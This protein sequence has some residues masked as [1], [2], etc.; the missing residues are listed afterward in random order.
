MRKVNRQTTAC[1][2]IFFERIKK[3]DAFDKLGVICLVLAALIV[4]PLSLRLFLGCHDWLLVILAAI[5]SFPL[6]WI[7]GLNTLEFLTK[8][9]SEKG[10]SGFFTWVIAIVLGLV[11]YAVMGGFLYYLF[12]FVQVI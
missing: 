9:F 8:P 7:A 4:A 11:V 1:Q 12:K 2:I 10:L 5:I 3:M 6:L